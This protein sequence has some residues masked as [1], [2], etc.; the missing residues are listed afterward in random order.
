M[1]EIVAILTYIY[2]TETPNIKESN[3]L[4]KKYS[5]FMN[6]EDAE[7]DIFSIFNAIM[8]NG[9]AEMFTN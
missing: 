9:H 6:E 2:F 7:A 8:Q 5:L 1:N 4:S 3:L